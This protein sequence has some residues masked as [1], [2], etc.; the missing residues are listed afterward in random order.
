MKIDQKK[1]RHTQPT[2]VDLVVIMDTSDSMRDEA[3][4]LS[5]AVEAAIEAAR[6]KCPSDLRVCW[7]GIEGTWPG[8]KFTQ[9]YRD[10]LHGLGVRDQQI[11]G[12]RRGTVPYQGAQEEGAA[13]IVDISH[14]F[15][16]RLGAS[17]AIF[18]LGDEPLKEGIPQTD[19]DIRAADQAVEV[20][21]GKLVKVFTYIGTKVGSVTDDDHAKVKAEYARL[22]AQTGG[23]S[24]EAP[25]TNIGGFET[26]LAEIICASDGG[27]CKGDVGLPR[28]QP[29]FELDWGDGEDDQIETDDI[30]ILRIVACNPY[31]NIILKDVTV[32]LSALTQD[33]EPVIT[34]PDGTSSVV[35]VPSQFICFGDL[36]P[37]DPAKPEELTGVTRELVLASRG[38]IPGQYRFS[39]E[40]CYS[41]Q[42]TQRDSK[43][44]TLNLVDS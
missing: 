28:V 12:R 42:S 3:T 2:P 23:Q 27:P 9:S 29:R 11:L 43:Q 35:I 8:T 36:P 39:I 7:L 16:W 21:L 30:E 5:S 24:Y 13:A 34:L 37:C 15:N 26:A 18:F 10:Y 1:S 31:S 44:F 41:V 19:A 38:A 25:L 14:H 32:F 20:A 6:T 33:G 17:R 40:C 4:A 22:A